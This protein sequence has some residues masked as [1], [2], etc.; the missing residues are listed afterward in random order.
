MTENASPDPLADFQAYATELKRCLPRQYERS[1]NRDLSRQQS[2]DLFIR[3]VTATLQHAY[4]EALQR[5]RELPFT[6]ANPKP[7]AQD[8][9]Q[10]FAG[11]SDELIQV[12]LQKHRTSC[13]LSNFPDEHKPNRDYIAAVLEAVEKDRLAFAARVEALFC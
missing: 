13:A 8:V 2:Q 1:I 5:L 11:L 4:D 3:N 9:L 7:S 10:P 6:E 12:A